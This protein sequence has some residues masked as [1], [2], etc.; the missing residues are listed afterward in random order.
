MSASESAAK[1]KF[2]LRTN[3]IQALIDFLHGRGFRTAGPTIRDCAVIYDEIKGIEQIPF[4]VADEQEAGFYRVKKRKEA[5]Y[6]TYVVGAHS[7]KKFLNPPRCTLWKAKLDNGEMSLIADEPE[8]VPHYAFIGVRPC[9]IAAIAVQDRVFQDGPY[10]D[11][12]YKERRSA[13]AII[14]VNCAHPGGTCFCVSMDTGPEAKS[15]F[16]L[17]LT[18]IQETNRHLF[19]ATTGSELGI[20]IVKALNLEQATS[21]EIADEAAV[22]NRAAGKMGRKIDTSHI[23]EL[24]QRNEDHPRWN[25]VGDRCLNCANCTMVCPTCFCMT[26]EDTTDI[27]GKIAERSRR[28][29]SCFT[30]EFSHIHGG[31]VRT[32]ASARYRHWM[33]HKLA[34]WQDQFGVSGCVGCGRCITWCPVGIDITEEA[35]AIR[36]SSRGD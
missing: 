11:N 30:I 7:W 17:S 13:I 18:E 6:F 23:N 4:G 9:E 2:I 5:G 1:T 27:T 8:T 26:V 36:S 24:L 29:D 35:A 33:T 20:E 32:S 12:L 31:A 21:A 28:W 19:V 3:Q 16:D 15:G 25:H 10:V 14:A 22:M 34:T